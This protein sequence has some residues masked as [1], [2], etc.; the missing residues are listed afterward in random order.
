VILNLNTEHLRVVR[1][2]TACIN[3]ITEALN[4]LPLLQS[5]V[6][7][8]TNNSL[9][10][11][12]G[13]S[14]FAEYKI[15]NDTKIYTLVAIQNSGYINS[16]TEL[17]DTGAF[18][19]QFVNLLVKNYDVTSDEAGDFFS[20]LCS[21]QVLIPEIEPN[22]TGIDPLDELLHILENF[23]GVENIKNKL[24]GIKTLLKNKRGGISLYKEIE[25]EIKKMELAE[26]LPKNLLQVDM[27]LSAQKNE[28][29]RELI[30]SISGQVEDLLVLSKKGD[31][32]DLGEFIRKFC[33]KYEDAE[34]ALSIALDS[35]MGIGFAGVSEVAS[36]ADLI[37][38]LAIGE[39][40]TAQIDFNFIQK[41][42]SGK[43]NSYLHGTKDE[44]EI[45]DA[46]TCSY[47]H[48]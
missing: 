46:A 3:Q 5:Q 15:V 43:Y 28:I 36:S 31:N 44:I 19:H 47:I 22:V 37:N 2:D 33:L 41:F 39:T 32:E 29:N 30:N 16:I 13:N 18:M 27:Y 8:T 4:K 20:A 11:A 23:T 21:K 1:I 12:Q 25:D 17:S 10:K 7:Y 38:D 14:R 6:K 35:E 40:G 24:A 45:T 42:A 9:Y 34:I 48:F 26:P